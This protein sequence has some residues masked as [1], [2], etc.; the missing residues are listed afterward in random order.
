[1]TVSCKGPILNTFLG[2]LQ[3]LVL[4]IFKDFCN[5]LICFKCFATAVPNVNDLIKFVAMLCCMANI[6]LLH[7]RS[8][9]WF[10]TPCCCH[11]WPQFSSYCTCNYQV[12]IHHFPSLIGCIVR[13]PSPLHVVLFGTTAG[14]LGMSVL[15]SQVNGL[16]AALG[17]EIS[18][19]IW[20]AVLTVMIVM[21]LTEVIFQNCKGQD[22]IQSVSF[23]LLSLF[24]SIESCWS[25]DSNFIWP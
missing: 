12:S 14:L 18:Y 15:L 5:I 6:V 19:E 23:H 1:M 3:L 16:T 13:F 7:V 2:W 10:Q 9:A 8:T 25:T 22:C 20:I 24:I 21:K 17:M 11:C 4:I